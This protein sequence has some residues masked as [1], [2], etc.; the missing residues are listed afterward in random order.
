LLF[1][2]AVDAVQSS[3]DDA[4]LSQ[5]DHIDAVQSP[6]DDVVT[7]DDAVDVYA[8]VEED[9][10]MSAEFPLLGQRQS[11]IQSCCLNNT[12]TVRNRANA[13]LLSLGEDC[14]NDDS[15]PADND[16]ASAQEDITIHISA[17]D[18][19]SRVKNRKLPCFYCDQFLFQ[20]SRHLVRKHHE[21]PAV[22]ASLRDKLCLQRIVNQGVYKHNVTVLQAKDGV[23]I[24]GRAPA[25]R[26]SVSDYLPCQYCL[27]FFISEE[28]YRHCKQCR[29]RACND[30]DAFLSSSRA[31]L[32]GS[33]AD[34]GNDIDETLRQSVINRMRCDRLTSIVKTDQLI[35]KLGL[36]LLNKLGAKRALDISAR[37]RELAR[38]LDNLPVDHRHNRTLDAC[39]SRTGFDVTLKAIETVGK[40]SVATGGRRVFDRPAFVIKAGNSILKCAHLKRGQALRDVLEARTGTA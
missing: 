30:D 9:S 5:T 20:M 1:A 39:I 10:N 13:E 21:E 36:T 27:Q 4:V 22:A 11:V 31:L 17:K 23:L 29:F 25:K 37:M 12:V 40:P 16:A 14:T 26:R 6:A 3:A 7:A 35:L 33:L 34:S 8:Y 15:G 38:V 18:H 2:V 32:A 24:V 28:L 19:N